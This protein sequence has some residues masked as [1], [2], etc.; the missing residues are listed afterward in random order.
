MAS[1]GG[2]AGTSTAVLNGAGGVTVVAGDGKQGAAYDAHN[3]CP[4]LEEIPKKILD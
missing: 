1:S 4:D 3:I 2:D